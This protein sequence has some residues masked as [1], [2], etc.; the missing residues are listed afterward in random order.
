[1]RRASIFKLR[2]Y[3]HISALTILGP[4]VPLPAWRRVSNP[5]RPT[6]QHK[7][8]A[9]APGPRRPLAFFHVN[10][11]QQQPAHGKKRHQGQDRRPARPGRQRQQGKNRRP[12]NPANFSH[13]AKKPKNSVERWR[14][15]KLANSER[16]SA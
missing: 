13:T 12:E 6:V 4:S 16:L 2:H 10:P 5:S 14:G 1:M 11:G 15:I 3:R 8:T 7:A 9:S